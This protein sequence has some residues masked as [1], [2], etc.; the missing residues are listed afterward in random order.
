[1]WVY[2]KN[3]IVFYKI[4]VKEKQNHVFKY[5]YFPLLFMHVPKISSFPNFISLL[6]GNSQ[7]EKVDSPEKAAVSILLKQNGSK[8][9]QE[10]I[11][12]CYRSSMFSGR[13]PE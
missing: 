12:L 5:K 1:M 3:I 7:K 13:R 4:P 2:G 6:P 11:H 8:T 9:S 10:A